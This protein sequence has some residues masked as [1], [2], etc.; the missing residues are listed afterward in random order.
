MLFFSLLLIKLFSFYFFRPDISLS[1]FY[2]VIFRFLFPIFSWNQ[3]FYTYFCTH[4]REAVR[5]LLAH[6]CFFCGSP[7]LFAIPI[8]ME[9]FSINLVPR[10]VHSLLSPSAYRVTPENLVLHC[11]CN[12][13]L[14]NVGGIE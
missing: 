9:R 10:C 8:C 1:P 3:L 5:R 6:F 4:Q 13:S 12:K 14:G 7:C 2:Y 11:E